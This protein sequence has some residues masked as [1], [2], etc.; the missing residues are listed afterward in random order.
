M[1]VA[2]FLVTS[3]IS[4]G[5]ELANL[6]RNNVSVKT[7]ILYTLGLMAIEEPKVRWR[8]GFVERSGA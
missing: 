3:C 5:A 4:E 1:S 8:G 7:P 6:G 2:G